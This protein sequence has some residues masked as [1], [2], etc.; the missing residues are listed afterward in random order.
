M[1]RVC[2]FQPG[3]RL[4]IDQSA[5]DFLLFFLPLIDEWFTFQEPRVIL[6]FSVFDII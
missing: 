2:S 1:P 5:D 4:V 3:L 6:V